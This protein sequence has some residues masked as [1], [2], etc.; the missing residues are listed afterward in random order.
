MMSSPTPASLN[1]VIAGVGGQG[2]V[3]A[4]KLLAQAALL[5]GRP[6]RTAETIGMAQRGGSVLGHVRIG[7]AASPLVPQRS[8][9][10]L[11]GF[12]PGETVRAL[13]YLQHG[14][15]VITATQALEPVTAA[16]GGLPYDGSAE[17]DYLRTLEAS[18]Q[19]SA[20][21]AVDGT[22]LCTELGST[23]VLNVILLGAALATGALGL[24]PASLEA[25]LKALV[26]PAYIELNEKA[27]RRGM[28]AVA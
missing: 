25:A 12:E 7:Q 26:K 8:A 5:E 15:T 21:V 1:I 17:L 22:A 9:N 11:I 14:G 28:E 13:G 20:L 10:V 2:T 18:G 24:K 4:S 3:L 16:L 27:L 6:V 23:R 19:L